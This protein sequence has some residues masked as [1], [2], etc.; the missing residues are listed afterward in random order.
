MSRR[1]LRFYSRKTIVC[2]QKRGEGFLQNFVQ[3]NFWP[4]LEADLVRISIIWL[5]IYDLCEH[6]IPWLSNFSSDPSVPK[7]VWISSLQ[8]TKNWYIFDHSQS[9]SDIELGS[10]LPPLH[11]HVCFIVLLTINLGFVNETITREGGCCTWHSLYINVWSFE[12]RSPR[13]AYLIAER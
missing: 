3:L 11:K 9:L 10:P 8:F 7:Y 1:L 4:K 13:V 5:I 6:D 12:P 2:C